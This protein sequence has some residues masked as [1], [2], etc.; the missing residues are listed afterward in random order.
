MKAAEI[1][2]EELLTAKGAPLVAWREKADFFRGGKY[3]KGEV[4]ES[5]DVLT[6]AFTAGVLID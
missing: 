4:I 3:S 1:L 2:T 6:Q 5:L